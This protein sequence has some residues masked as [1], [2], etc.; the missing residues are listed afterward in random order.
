MVFNFL[1]VGVALLVGLITGAH[2]HTDSTRTG[3]TCKQAVTINGVAKCAVY[4]NNDLIH[5]LR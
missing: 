3:L 5:E 4:I 2:I 1:I